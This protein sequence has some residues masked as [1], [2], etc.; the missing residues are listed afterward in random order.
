MSSQMPSIIIAKSS[1]P[2]IEQTPYFLLHSITQLP[3]SS[4]RQAS[5]S[6]ASPG[7]K[8]GGGEGQVVPDITL[9]ALDPVC[10]SDWIPII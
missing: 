4:M 9:S 8:Q 2:R 6:I 1:A 3:S 10:D 5:V 7:A